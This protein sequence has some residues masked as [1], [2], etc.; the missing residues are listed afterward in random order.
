[1]VYQPKKTLNW[2]ISHIVLFGIIFNFS[3]ADVCVCEN[4]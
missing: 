1:M 4:V 2:D 3:A